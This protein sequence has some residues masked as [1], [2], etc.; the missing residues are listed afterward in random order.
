MILK[1]AQKLLSRLS[2]ARKFLL[3]YSLFTVPFLVLSYQVVKTD[4]EQMHL[5]SRV[6][7]NLQSLR[8]IT[9]FLH[10]LELLRDLTPLR[11][12][13]P[14]SPGIESQY[15]ESRRQVLSH[16]DQL[17][18]Y[19]F[20]S[21]GYLSEVRSSLSDSTPAA[22]GSE[23][24]SID[25]VFAN[26]NQLVLSGYEWRYQVAARGGLFSVSNRQLESISA[27]LMNT[28]PRAMEEAGKA[29][30]YGSWFLYRKHVDPGSV[31][32][33]DQTWKG[34][35]SM[36]RQLDTTGSSDGATYG[37]T[38]DRLRKLLEDI[39]L[40]FDDRLIQV[41]EL[42]TSWQDFFATTSSRINQ[43]QAL[44]YSLYDSI[45]TSIDADLQ[46][47]RQSLFLHSSAILLVLAG[48][49]YLFAGFYRSVRTAI[50]SL[51]EGAGNVALGKYDQAITADTRDELS[52]LAASMDN[53]RLKLKD[54]EDQLRDF[55]SR[56]GLTGLRNR[57]HFDA[58]LQ[59]AISLAN[60]EN[61]WL[62]L[63][64]VD[65][66]FFKKLNDEHGHQAG[67]AALRHVATLFE[68]VFRKRQ[69]LIARYG[70]E[71]FGI[72]IVDAAPSLVAARAEELRTLIAAS[73][74]IFEDTELS[75]SASIGVTTRVPSDRTSPEKLIAEADSALYRA[76]SL[77]R[78]R[79]EQWSEPGR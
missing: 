47:K 29:R 58:A 75:I 18:D 6:Q 54:R 13:A 16:L 17:E 78:N 15:E 21:G 65:L 48:I 57:R 42:N 64:L 44:T 53:M 56:D 35:D 70:G 39:Q 5:V 51:S 10:H 23:L 38:A 30:S 67:D 59:E 46:E 63:I 11:I 28:L 79:V 69:D 22:P 33:I 45:S 2:Y 43:V 26:A 31:F 49:A 3:V 61:C 52:Q 68:E 55:G 62:A 25:N 32:L 34:L 27:I 74:V 73:P 37:A 24:F 60:R 71:E 72:I 9:V 4:Y 20:G 19:E 12:A 40:H 8:S 7:E 50:D 77:G 41:L 14:E 66:D 1:P 76:K 36:I